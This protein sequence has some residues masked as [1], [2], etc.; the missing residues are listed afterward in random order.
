MLLGLACLVAYN[1]NLRTLGEGDTT[2][3]R[4]QPLILWKDKT[5]ALGENVQLVGRGHPLRLVPSQAAA[6]GSPGYVGYY[7]P[8]AYW[9]VPTDDSG[10]AASLYP[11]VT[12]LLVAP[13]YLPAYLWLEGRGWKQPDI[14]RVAEV[15]EKLSASL[16]AYLASVLMF[17]LLRREKVPWAL[18]LSIAFA[19]GTNTWMISSQALWQHGTAEILVVL[20]LGL[21]LLERS[22]RRLVLLGLVCALM[23]ANRPPDAI[24][25]AGFLL[26]ALRDK[27]DLR[28]LVLGAALPLLA[29]LAYN[30]ATYGNPVGGYA[31]REGSGSRFFRVDLAGPAGMLLSPGRGLLVFTPFLLFLPIGVAQRLKDPRTRRLTVFV[32]VACL[33]QLLFYSQ[34]DWRAGVSWG[35]RWLTDMLPILVWLLAPVPEVLRPHAR[36]VLVATMAVAVG[37]Q[38]IGAFWY[39]RVSDERLF[40][41]PPTS[42]REVWKPANT[43]FVVE[44]QHGPAGPELQC[45]ARGVLERVGDTLN[46]GDGAVLRLEQDMV[47]SGWA[48][49][50]KRTPAQ[51]AVFVDGVV[52]GTTTTFTPRPDV[53]DA[54][55]TDGPTGWTVT[56][57]VRGVR[58][59]RHVLSLG[60]R[61]EPRS[62]FRIVREE[63]VDVPAPGAPIPADDDVPGMAARAAERLRADQRPDGAWLTRHTT[64]PR[65]V[66]PTDELNTYTTPVLVDLLR[67]VAAEHGLGDALSRARA[68]IAAQIEPTGLVRYHGLPDGPDIGT[69]GCRITPDADDTALAWRVAGRPTDDPRAA[70]MLGTLARYRDGR[71]LYRTWLAPRARY[72]CIDPGRDPNPADLVNQMHVYLMLRR[73]DPPAGRRLCRAIQR[74]AAAD[75][76][77]V[78]YDRAP[79]LPYLRSAELARLGCRLPL[80]AARLAGAEPGQGPWA[81][82][83]RLLVDVLDGRELDG[84]RRREVRDVL[85]RLGRDDFALLRRTPPLA[86]HN[87]LT[88][89]VDRYYWSE[90]LGYALWLRL[91]AE[92]RK[93][94]P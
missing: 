49:A 29:L 71:G 63:T 32:G 74:A 24:L 50:C 69:L 9:M 42:L 6:P 51:V 85:T 41:G 48:Y 36:R 62:E 93:R 60:V 13:L 18:P 78:Y 11:V 66:R 40:S 90:D 79:L 68:Q 26:Y 54:L 22:P 84:P 16:I 61:V 7:A 58:P 27:R 8:H 19:F 25:A 52:V 88:A 23:A 20:A 46:R 76:A 72:E 56:A 37:V 43:P 2:S 39:T 12:P 45:G 38:L 94:L 31:D 64:G 65:Y 59:G 30:L 57:A 73:F 77:V 91:Y 4:Y 67:P 28:W 86:Y 83:V 70:G 44:L 80:P 47:L 21:C 81:E 82:L 55:G 34:T 3:A 15:M 33:V 89:T 87:D 35:P 5:L 17:L 14:D 53:D 10:G 92:A 75:D 1:A